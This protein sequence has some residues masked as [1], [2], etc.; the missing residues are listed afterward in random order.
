MP[1]LI[2]VIYGPQYPGHGTNCEVIGSVWGA[3][4]YFKY[5]GVTPYFDLNSFRFVGS[6]QY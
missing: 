1:I 3:T 4:P 6:T 5:V 2:L